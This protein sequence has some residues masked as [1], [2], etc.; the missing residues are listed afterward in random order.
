MSNK[1]AVAKKTPTTAFIDFY[2]EQLGVE[3]TQ[4][5]SR[6]Y[7]LVKQ[8][9][10]K[11]VQYTTEKGIQFRELSSP[12]IISAV[13]RVKALGI[14]LALPHMGYVVVY[15]DVLSIEPYKHGYIE[16]FR[17]YGADV[18]RILNIWSIREKDEF[19]APKFIGAK[20][21]D[22]E[23]KQNTTYGKV[24]KMVLQY[25]TDYGEIKYLMA[26]RNNIIP[27][28]IGHIKKIG[29]NKFKQDVDKAVDKIQELDD[30]DKA[31]KFVRETYPHLLSPAW[32]DFP[33]TMFE[34]KMLNFIVRN[35]PI[36]DKAPMHV[37]SAVK[38]SID[39]DFVEVHQPDTKQNDK[40]VDYEIKEE[41]VV[42]SV[43]VEVEEEYEEPVKEKET[44][45]SKD[46]EVVD[47]IEP[48]VEDE[49]YTVVEET[50]EIVHDTPKQEPKAETNNV[51][52][53]DKPIVDKEELT[54]EEKA[55][56]SFLED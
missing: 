41:K 26:E 36:S 28:L 46:F 54:E 34:T 38:E 49:E 4:E 21:T 8:S 53:Q 7:N 39:A 16:I 2:L 40:K 15:G 43:K 47:E 55:F 5:S 22:A 14:N 56:A 27:S 23:Y 44:N 19:V 29:G 31:Y 18:K 3:N 1:N 24:I 50:G 45:V 33:E 35:H 51:D 12:S 11:I 48:E 20:M 42:G 17:N 30:F 52:P 37:V 10:V 25:E 6:E 9:L 32:K 13:E